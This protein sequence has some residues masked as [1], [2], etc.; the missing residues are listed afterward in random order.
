MLVDDREMNDVSTKITSTR[1][2]TFPCL[3]SVSVHKHNDRRPR[4]QCTD[5]RPSPGVKSPCRL[6]STCALISRVVYVTCVLFHFWGC[7]M[8]MRA[9]HN[10]QGLHLD[11][12]ARMW[13]SQSCA[14]H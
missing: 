5:Q 6:H 4:P 14:L 9:Q 8:T 2:V 1:P 10:S 11:Y 13:C 3:L 7:T 12:S